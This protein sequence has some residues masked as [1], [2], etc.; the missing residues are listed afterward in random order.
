MNA[1]ALMF[2]LL[3]IA[4][5]GLLCSGLATILKGI[6]TMSIVS[7]ILFVVVVAAAIKRIHVIVICLLRTLLPT[8]WIVFIALTSVTACP[9]STSPLASMSPP[10]SNSSS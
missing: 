4:S 3:T 1:I 9:S 5:G 10:A 6:S 2:G 7:A 8:K